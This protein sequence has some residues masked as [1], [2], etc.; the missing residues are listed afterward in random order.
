MTSTVEL[1]TT[2]RRLHIEQSQR[3]CPLGR[4]S[5]PV[6]EELWIGLCR[7]SVLVQVDCS[8][9]MRTRLD[10]ER[11]AV[12]TEYEEGDREQA[13]HDAESQFQASFKLIYDE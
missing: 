13:A 8:A 6:L 10:G 7:A 2:P 11:E 3:R 12:A 1:T 4:V 9:R 5:L